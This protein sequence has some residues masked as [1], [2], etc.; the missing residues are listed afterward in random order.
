MWKIVNGRLLQT[1]DETRSRYKTRI[2]AALLEELKQLAVQHETH[3]GYL[4]EDGFL[5]MLQQGHINYDKKNRPNDRIE[6][7]TTCDDELLEQLRE[8]AKLQQLNLN[9]V[10]EESAKYIR[11]EE[12]KNANWRYRVEL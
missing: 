11:V 3:I 10:I 5:H 8:F 6:F 4:L 1:T 12:V 9:D 7:R 2:S